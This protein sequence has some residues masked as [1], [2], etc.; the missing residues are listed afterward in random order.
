MLLDTIV[1]AL[2]SYVSRSL[3]IEAQFSS[4]FESTSMFTYG[5]NGFAILIYVSGRIGIFSDS[6]IY[7]YKW[8]K[9]SL[10]VRACC[11]IHVVFPSVVGLLIFIH[12]IVFIGWLIWSSWAL[13]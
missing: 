13:I 3:L 7:G 2:A 6:N 4:V 8:P 5:L 12:C 11:I 10:I 1:A 9:E